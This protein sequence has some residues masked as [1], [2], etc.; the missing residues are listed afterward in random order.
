MIPSMNPILLTFLD[1]GLSFAHPYWSWAL[2]LLLPLLWLFIDAGR[3]R[4][5][6]LTKIL[7]PRLKQLLA[8][9]VSW[10]LRNFRIALFFSA[11]AFSFLALVQPRLGFIDQPVSYTHLTLPTILRV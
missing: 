7:A 3:R 11:I 5:A 8:G 4:D 1:E 2:F 10:P 6:L 9:Q